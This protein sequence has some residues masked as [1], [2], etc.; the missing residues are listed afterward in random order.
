[1]LLFMCACLLNPTH[2]CIHAKLLNTILP[3]MTH[4]IGSQK[5]WHA[6]LPAFLNY[7]LLEN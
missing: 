7:V 2:A 1:M 5:Q 4:V 3:K 6:W